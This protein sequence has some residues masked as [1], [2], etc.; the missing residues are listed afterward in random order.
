MAKLVVELPH[1]GKRFIVRYPRR[2][3]VMKLLEQN[4]EAVEEMPIVPVA[5][6]K[7]R[8]PPEEIKSG[9]TSSR[10]AGGNAANGGE[11][12]EN[13][14]PESLD[15]SPAPDSS[16]TPLNDGTATRAATAMIEEYDLHIA[17]IPADGGRVN[18]A[19]V[20]AFLEALT[21]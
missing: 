19:H 3:T 6:D 20:V 9:P 11:A 2:E 10:E 14:S 1:E 12:I 7:P 21:E 4:A 17:E 5:M 13:L 16:S 15:P 18:K 8:I